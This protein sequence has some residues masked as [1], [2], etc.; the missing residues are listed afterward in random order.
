M[1][2]KGYAVPETKAAGERARL[3]I[4]RAEALG[5]PPEDP[6]LFFSVLY[7][8][9][10]GT[11]VTFDGDAMRN[12]AAQFLALAKT[13]AAAAPLMVGHILVGLSLMLGGAAAQSRVHFD[14]A[15][16]LCDPA[17][18][19]ALTTQFS[20]DV[21]VRTLLGR[22]WTLWLLGHPEAALRD[23]E[24]A[25][26]LAR[27]I[28]QAATLMYALG[29][30]TLVQILCGDQAAACARGREQ[31]VLAAE[32]GAPFWNAFGVMN[33]GC[34]LVL[35][36][37]P[38]RAIELLI[39]GIAMAQAQR[40]T[41]WLPFYFAHLARAHA[42][43]GRFEDACDRIDEA[44]TAVEATGKHGTRRKFT[45]RLEKLN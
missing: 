41:M 15:I 13:Q 8:S 44:L 7:S 38:S 40:S 24:S 22:A 16:A 9:W 12:L 42:E 4:E 43:L 45:G 35:V 32:R 33:Q 23:A 34:A 37:A 25:L 29:N 14:Q 30:S 21:S 3:L 10:A 18:H 36:G 6:L 27:E 2:A 26:R 5:E 28:G 20:I 11:Y 1:H 31:A 19:R 39:A 17:K